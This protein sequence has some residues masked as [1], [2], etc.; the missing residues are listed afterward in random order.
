MLAKIILITL[1]LVLLIIFLSQIDLIGPIKQ[2][3]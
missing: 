2:V 3:F 1:A